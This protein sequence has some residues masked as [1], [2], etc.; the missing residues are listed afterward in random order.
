ML[1]HSSTAAV[2]ITADVTQVELQ[3]L[4]AMVNYR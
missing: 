3:I 1:G 4:F 2:G